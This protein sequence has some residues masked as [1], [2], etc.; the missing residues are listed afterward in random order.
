MHVLTLRAKYRASVLVKVGLPEIETPVNYAWQ[1]H[2]FFA[3][4]IAPVLNAG[5]GA[6][7]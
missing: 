7:R 1:A 3:L 6:S 5:N 2:F 4:L